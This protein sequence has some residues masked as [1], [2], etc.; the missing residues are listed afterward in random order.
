MWSQSS[1]RG[2]HAALLFSVCGAAS[3]QLLNLEDWGI[4]LLPV[5]FGILAAWLCVDGIV[6]GIALAILSEGVWQA[7][8]R[9]AERMGTEG[10]TGQKVFAMCLAGLIGGFGVALA[11]AASKRLA[12]PLAALGTIAIAGAICALPFAAWLISGNE[13][14]LPEWLQMLLSF[15]IWQ[16]AVG[17]GLWRSFG[18]G[19]PAQTA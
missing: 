6:P 14:P 2:T 19:R 1:V 10:G 11:T 9:V 3:S 5:P 15:A 4:Y 18:A 17:F 7:A 13:A 8:Y 16:G 12:P